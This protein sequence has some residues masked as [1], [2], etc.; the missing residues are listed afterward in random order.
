MA[1]ARQADRPIP[2]SAIY[3]AAVL[4]AATAL[5]AVLLLGMLLPDRGVAP[6]TDRG[7]V[8]PAVLEAGREWQR[9]REQQG[10]FVDPVIQSGRD[11]EEQRKQQ[12]G[13]S[14]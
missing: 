10:G 1:Q 5:A 11:W 3:L 8:S 14:E 4:I 2:Q 12:S 7:E 13:A 6:A 9:Q